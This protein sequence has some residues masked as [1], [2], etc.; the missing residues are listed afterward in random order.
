MWPTEQ[1]EFETPGLN[2]KPSCLTAISSH[3]LTALPAKM[4]ACDSYIRQNA[5]HH[6]LKCIFE[7]LLSCYCYA[8]KANIRTIRS[9]VSQPASA[10]KEVNLVNCKL[11]TACYQNSETDSCAVWMS[12]RQTT[13]LQ[14]L[15]RLIRIKQLISRFPEIFAS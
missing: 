4:S 9:R 13:V 14:E 1:F 5:S 2:Y 6:D 10:G 12:Y 15:T 11:I 8:T 3:C 7:D